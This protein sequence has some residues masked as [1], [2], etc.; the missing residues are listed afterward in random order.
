[1]LIG[2]DSKKFKHIFVTFLSIISHLETERLEK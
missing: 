1:M 2:G